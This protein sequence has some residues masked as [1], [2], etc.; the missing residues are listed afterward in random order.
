MND[1]VRIRFVGE[2]KDS[3][4]EI[5]GHP[6]CSSVCVSPYGGVVIYD[7]DKKLVDNISL[8]NLIDAH[9]EKLE[10]ERIF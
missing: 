5:T 9:F 1:D 6:R 7:A 10:R 4:Y 2:N 8:V 3:I